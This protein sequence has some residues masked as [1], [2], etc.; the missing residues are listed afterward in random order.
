M[1]T[2]LPSRGAWI[3]I[4][5]AMV[6]LTSL[7]ASLPSRGAWIEIETAESCWAADRRR[8]PHGERG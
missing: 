8:S 1:N 7:I 3:E 6:Y 5:C 4:S 2:S